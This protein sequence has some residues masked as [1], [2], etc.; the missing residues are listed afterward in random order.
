MAEDRTFTQEEVNKL[1]G[2]ARLEGKDAVRKE[3]DGWISPD[4]FTQKTADLNAQ[5]TGLSDQIKALTDEKTNL[6]TLLTE[7]DGQIAKYETDSVKTKIAKEFELSYE[8][9]EFLQGGTEEEIRKSAAALKGILGKPYVPPA[10][11]NDPAPSG[12]EKS[13]AWTKMVRDLSNE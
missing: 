6:Q 2:A 7:K 9:A 13:V 1:V 4:D 10:Y 8:A 5:L 3:F 12:D 11:N